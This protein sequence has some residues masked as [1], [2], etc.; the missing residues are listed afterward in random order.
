MERSRQTGQGSQAPRNNATVSSLSFMFASYIADLLL[1]KIAT[2][3][4]LQAQ[5]GK[6]SPKVGSLQP[7]D[8]KRNILEREKT[9]RKKTSLLQTN[10]TEK[11][12]ALPMPARVRWVAQTSTC[13]PGCNKA[14]LHTSDAQAAMQ[15]TQHSFKAPF[16]T[17][18][19]G[20]PEPVP[21]PGNN[22]ILYLLG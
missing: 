21:L 16:H 10:T 19:P 3:K 12:V 22:K 13:M 11:T 7:K 18:S 1:K 14:P 4:C 6:K 9:L 17:I 20:D 5:T 2:Q 8:Q 15:G